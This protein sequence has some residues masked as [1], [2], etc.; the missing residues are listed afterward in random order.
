MRKAW[1]VITILLLALGGYTC[2]GSNDESGVESKVEGE[3]ESLEEKAGGEAKQVESDIGLLEGDP[4][5]LGEAM[6]KEEEKIPQPQEEW[7]QE[8]DSMGE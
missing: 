3:V 6:G 5:K 7:G 8:A 4:E 1:V 2:G